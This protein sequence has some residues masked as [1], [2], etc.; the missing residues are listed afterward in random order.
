VRGTSLSIL[1]LIKLI[2]IAIATTL[3]RN[4]GVHIGRIV[5]Y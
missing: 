1:K 5:Y 2:R 4:C 3:A